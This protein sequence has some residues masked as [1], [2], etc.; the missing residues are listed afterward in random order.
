M[1][2][3]RTATPGGGDGSTNSDRTLDPAHRL[4]S[5][6]G[7]RTPWPDGRVVKPEGLHGAAYM[8]VIKPLRNLIVHPA[9]V[10]DIERRWRPDPTSQ[11]T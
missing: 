1:K 2:L 5:G 7:R 11:H 9:L 3:P 6:R 8:A 4:G 10:R